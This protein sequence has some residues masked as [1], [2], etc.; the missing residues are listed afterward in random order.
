MTTQTTVEAAKNG[1]ATK[2]PLVPPDEKFW[3]RYSPH[4]EAPLSGVSFS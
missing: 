3:V 1:K 2:K 4:H